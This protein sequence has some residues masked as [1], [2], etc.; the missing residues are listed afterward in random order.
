ML[1]ERDHIGIFGKM[2]S[3]KSS[4]MNMLTQQETSIVDAT[5]GTTADTKVALQE[6]HGMGP[7]KLFDTAGL[8]E[9]SGLGLNKRARVLADLKE[10]DLVL[11][12]IDPDTRSF[13]TEAEVLAGARELDKQILVIYNL[14][15]ASAGERI[16]FVEKSIPLLRFHRKISLVAVDAAWRQPLLE[17]TLTNFVS[18]NAKMELPPFIKWGEFHVLNIPMD[19]RGHRNGPDSPFHR[20]ALARRHHRAQLRPGVP[21]QREMGR[22]RRPRRAREQWWAQPT[23][24]I[25]RSLRW[26]HDQ[27]PEAAR[28][29]PR[30]RFHRCLVHELR[31]L[32]GLHAGSGGPA[33][34]PAALGPQ[35]GALTIYDLPF[36]ICGR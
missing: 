17:F 12:V 22:D 8:D 18:K 1:V 15:R 7:A 2:N 5:P 4:I 23:L 16:S 35:C 13:A 34:R 10:C 25:G 26:L 28:P 36:T 9:E 19:C 27:R 24:Q 3:G 14:F 30:P 33:P 32:S 31:H 11:L 20:A 21:R 29:H 6:I